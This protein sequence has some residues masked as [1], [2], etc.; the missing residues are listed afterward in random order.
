MSTSSPSA[1]TH[2]LERAVAALIDLGA[3]LSQ[4]VAHMS[5]APSRPLGNG[6]QGVPIPRVL[7]PLLVE[8]LRP[9][10]ARSAP[11]SI[12]DAARLLEEIATVLTD[13]ILL[14]PHDV[15]PPRPNRAQRR[16]RG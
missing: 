3:H 8:T 6:G 12:G 4:M 11:G 15:Q 1:Q 2:D 7:G 16:R 5:R 9:L 13:E 14:V 10:E